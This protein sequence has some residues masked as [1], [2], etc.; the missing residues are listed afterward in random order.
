M[1]YKYTDLTNNMAYIGKGSCV[2]DPEDHNYK[3]SSKE[4]KPMNNS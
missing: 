1:S 3:T 2:G 4:V